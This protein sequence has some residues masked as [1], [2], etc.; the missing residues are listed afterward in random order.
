MRVLVL[1]VSMAVATAAALGQTSPEV[2][3]PGNEAA[4]AAI[5]AGKGKCQTCHRIGTLGSR[6]GPDLT[7]I[8][9]TRTLEQLQTSLLDPDAEI[10]P[11]NR[12]YRVVTRDGVTISGRLLNH[13]TY[14]VLMRDS[15]DQL[16]SF[17]KSE[18]REHGFVKG[19]AMPSF[20]TTLSREELA[21]VIAYLST[22]KGVV[23]Q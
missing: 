8:G 9:A 6:L 10:L 16:R 18:L 19:S 22:L 20:R 23:A 14:Q 11:E 2:L 3:P 17:A 1:V 4:G 7:D 15:K 21:D 5:V 13:D 12:F